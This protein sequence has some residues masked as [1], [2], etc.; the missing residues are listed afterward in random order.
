MFDEIAANSYNFRVY[1]WV[2]SR[3][4][5]VPMKGVLLEECYLALDHAGISAGQTSFLATKRFAVTDS[6]D[7]EPV[8][9]HEKWTNRPLAAS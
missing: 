8:Q 1:A 3:S 9:Q 7:I 2:P 6:W 4:D 5:V